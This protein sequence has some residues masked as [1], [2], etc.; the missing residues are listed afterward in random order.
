MHV[1]AC[2]DGSIPVAI[3]RLATF[4]LEIYPLSE[5][6]GM[7]LG[8]YA[9][10]AGLRGAEKVVILNS[11]IGVCW[12]WQFASDQGSCLLKIQRGEKTS[13]VESYSGVPDSA[14]ETFSLF[15][16]GVENFKRVDLFA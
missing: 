2:D 1:C 12:V 3:C 8:E 11:T 16:I 14:G 6:L 10:K 4:G 13:L 9:F 5:V 7:G 15:G